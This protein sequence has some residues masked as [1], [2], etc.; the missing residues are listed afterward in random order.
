MASLSSIFRVKRDVGGDDVPRDM[1]R[2]PYLHLDAECFKRETL[3]FIVE[4]SE[5]R[6]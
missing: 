5:S 3:M 1:F 2:A 4:F 6:R